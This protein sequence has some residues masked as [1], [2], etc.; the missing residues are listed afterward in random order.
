MSKQIQAM[1]DKHPEKF[2][3]WHT[4]FDGYGDSHNDHLPSYWVYCKEGYI[5]PDNEC[6]SIH[7]KTVKEAVET[8]R[9]VQT[10]AEWEKQWQERRQA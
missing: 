1:I 9:T 6:G 8:M 7:T 5:I 2:D 4:E 3:S 10:V